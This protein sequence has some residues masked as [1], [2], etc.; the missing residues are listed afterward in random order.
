MLTDFP[1]GAYREQAIMHMYEIA[2]YWLED[3]RKEMMEREEQAQGKRMVVWPEYV[4]FE[5][6]K[7]FM[8]EEGRALEKLEQVRYNA[9]TGPLADKALFLAGR[10]KLFRQDY[11]EA[12][13]YF[14][15]L[16]EMHKN[17]PFAPQALELAIICKQLSTGG[18][19][20]DGRK[21]VEARKLVD[22]ALRSYPEL[23]NNKTDFLERQ[24]GS[25]TL[26]QAAKEYNGAEHY[27]RTGHPCSA[28]FCYQV[29][30]MRYPGT[31]YFDLATERMQE[32]HAKLE[33]QKNNPAADV[34]SPEQRA[35]S[36]GAPAV[37]NVP[38]AEMSP[39]GRLPA[40]LGER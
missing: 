16:V 19:E 20:Y 8:D 35:M 28:Y 7:P 3:T 23:A 11:K 37:P 6:P 33:K 26:Q 5:T 40:G 1:S 29:I 4:H 38:A 24:I 32:L 15:Q 30:R 12:E 13:H 21:L 39:P 36:A 2:N 14:S 27:R 25:I 34:P 17:S 10:V 31:K 18:P 22:T 9:M